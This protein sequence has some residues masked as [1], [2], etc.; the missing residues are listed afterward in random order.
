M[1]RWSARN[2]VSS[3][4]H[5]PSQLLWFHCCDFSV[6]KTL[7]V[8]TLR[9]MNHETREHEKYIFFVGARPTPP[10]TTKNPARGGKTRQ[11]G[12]LLY[13]GVFYHHLPPKILEKINNNIN[14]K[15]IL[16]Q[17]SDFRRTDWGTSEG[18]RMSFLS[19]LGCLGGYFTVGGSRIDQKNTKN[20]K[21]G[22][23]IIPKS[24]VRRNY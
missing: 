2:H 24:D 19:L 12:V 10:S 9:V 23:P 22:F 18:V 14:I 11:Q 5:T 6:C 13:S 7:Q 21:T 20:N 15:P 4:K 3:T 17:I 16:N 1:T 8:W